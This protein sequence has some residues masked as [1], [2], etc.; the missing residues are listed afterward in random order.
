MAFFLRSEPQPDRS[1]MDRKRETQVEL[2]QHNF[3]T[4]TITIAGFYVLSGCCQP[5]LMTLLKDSGLA[6]SSCQLYMVF[7]Y[8]GPAMFVFVLLSEPNFEWPS[9]IALLKGC[10]IACFDIFSSAMN[11][12]GAAL[13]GPTIFAIV[14]SSVTIWAALFSHFF[15]KRKMNFLQWIFVFSVFLG[16]TITTTHSRHLGSNV[17]HGTSLIVVGSAMH[18]LTYVMCE[19]IVR[20]FQSTYVMFVDKC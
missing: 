11:Y 15:L 16:L 3:G 14:Y 20:L 18:A 9:K 4:A 12:T 7:Y 5:L 19:G 17:I 10:G 13:A 8:L 6:D 2:A 1:N